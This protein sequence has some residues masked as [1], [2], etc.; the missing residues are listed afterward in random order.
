MR[1]PIDTSKMHFL[2]AGPAEPV[3]EF[4]TQ[5][6]KTDREGRAM[7]AVSLI[8]LGEEGAE[9]ITA[10]LSDEPRGLAQGLPVKVTGLVAS[11]WTM[12]ARSGITYYAERVEL[13]PLAKGAAAAAS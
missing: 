3:R 12:Q 5:R 8:V 9:V 10:K 7:F 4:Q 11:Y 6:Q 1:L 2:A 13:A